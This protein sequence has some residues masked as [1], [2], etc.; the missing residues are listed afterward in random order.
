MRK[1]KLMTDLPYI[2]CYE[3]KKLFII[4]LKMKNISID[5]G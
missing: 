5:E 4:K 3:K 1:K 2:I